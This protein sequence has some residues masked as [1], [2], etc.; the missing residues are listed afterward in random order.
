MKDTYEEMKTKQLEF[1]LSKTPQERFLIG[2]R[3]IEDG[4]NI[5]R[6]SIIN[7]NPDISEQELKKLVFKRCYA[8]DF[9]DQEMKQI[10]ANL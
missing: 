3:M 6:Q 9:S 10:I 5:V 7:N 1:L 2:I 4:I 8:N